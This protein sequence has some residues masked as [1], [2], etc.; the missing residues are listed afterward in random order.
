MDRGVRTDFPEFGLS[1]RAG[2]QL[3]MLVGKREGRSGC[4]L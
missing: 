2:E 3:T 4:R 1:P